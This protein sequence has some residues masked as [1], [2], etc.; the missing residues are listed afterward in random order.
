MVGLWR[1]SFTHGTPW[2]AC[3]ISFSC[4][5]F[6]FHGPVTGVQLLRPPW[7]GKPSFLQGALT[8]IHLKFTQLKF[9]A[10][11]KSPRLQTHVATKNPFVP[12]RSN[13]HKSKPR[14][15]Q[16]Q[17]LSPIAFGIGSETTELCDTYSLTIYK[18]VKKIYRF[19]IHIIS[20][21]CS[22]V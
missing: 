18:S 6:H 21:H 20:S 4:T 2:L 19:Y 13:S 5:L 22:F 12:L 16:N 17:M 8:K 15:G 1:S 9:L 11:L 14:S 10:W 7:S 3:P